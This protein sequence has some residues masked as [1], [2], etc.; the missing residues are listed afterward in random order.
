MKRYNLYDTSFGYGSI[1]FCVEPFR[2]EEV[3]LPRANIKSVCQSMEEY[4]YILDE[5]T[6]EAT[7]I[8]ELLTGYFAGEKI[9]IP[10]KV[11]DMSRFTLSQQAVYRAVADIRYGET[12]SYG[13]VARMANLPRAARFVGTTMAKNPYPVFIPCHRVIKS[14]GSIGKF[15]GGSDLKKNMLSL[16]RS[17]KGL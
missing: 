14:N 13:Q 12:A 8:L 9:D 6:P 3:S 11:M 17:R 10:W 5:N 4:S 2:L 7:T 1:V 16:E 15:G